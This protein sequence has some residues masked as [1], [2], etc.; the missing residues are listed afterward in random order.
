MRKRIQCIEINEDFNIYYI[1]DIVGRVW[2]TTGHD[3]ADAY[4]AISHGEGILTFIY[5]NPT[6]I[7]RKPHSYD[8]KNLV[9]DMLE[10]MDLQETT[11]YE[12]V[13]GWDN[14]DA[15]RFMKMSTLMAC[16]ILLDINKYIKGS[17]K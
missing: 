15:F 5:Y 14:A 8:F 17:V 16:D 10:Q 12:L 2:Y 6:T 9:L 7:N 4:D 1:R 13:I 11:E 3:E